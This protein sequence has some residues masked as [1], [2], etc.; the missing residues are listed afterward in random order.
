[1]E[2]TSRCPRLRVEHVTDSSPQESS[3]CPLSSSRSTSI[4]RP[5]TRRAMLA[6]TFAGLQRFKQSW[7]SIM[8]LKAGVGMS[9][10]SLDPSS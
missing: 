8:I 3:P 4:E 10:V 2:S 5:Q 9:Q 1:M 7:I 6:S